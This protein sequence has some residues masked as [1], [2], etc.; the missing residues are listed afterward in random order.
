VHA[1]HLQRQRIRLVKRTQAQ[2]RRGHRQP[3]LVRHRA[4][5]L[6]RPAVNHAAADVQ[7]RSLRGV[8]DIGGRLDLAHV[9][10]R[11]RLVAGQVHLQ[12]H[13]LVERLDRRVDG[14]VYQ[15]RTRAPGGGNVERFPD[16]PPQVLDALDQEVVLGDRAGDAG[17]VSLLEGVVADQVAADLPGERH[18]RRGVHVS[19]G[20]TGY[21]VRRARSGRGDHHAGPAGGLGEPL[22][23]VYR[24]L[25]MP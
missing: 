22:G 5:L 7:D 23:H 11:A 21:Q 15:H 4:Q 3:A 2:Q 20:Q 8:D 12:I 17:H 19:V 24:A 25:L 10:G 16:H 13:R 1:Q 14:D 18:Q 9:P 6:C